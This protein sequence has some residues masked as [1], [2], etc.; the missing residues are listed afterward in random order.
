MDQEGAT[1]LSEHKKPCSL[2]GRHLRT[3]HGKKKS[4]FA[5]KSDILGVFPQH[6]SLF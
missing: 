2:V 3:S 4:G 6:N 5:T 1:P